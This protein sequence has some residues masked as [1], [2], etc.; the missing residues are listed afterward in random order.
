MGQAQEVASLNREAYLA[1]EATQED[2]H[3]HI[4]GE[5]FEDLE[6]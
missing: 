2:R 5:V 4:A 1:W 3:E 6:D